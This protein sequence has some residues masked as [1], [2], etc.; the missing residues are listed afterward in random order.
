MDSFDGASATDTFFTRD[1]LDWCP[2]V[3]MKMVQC[4]RRSTSVGARSRTYQNLNVQKVAVPFFAGSSTLGW[5]LLLFVVG[6]ACG[7][8]LKRHLLQVRAGLHDEKILKPCKAHTD[9]AIVERHKP[10][11]LHQRYSMSLSAADPAFGCK[12]T[13]VCLRF[14]VALT[15]QGP[16]GK[17]SGEAFVCCHS[18]QHAAAPDGCYRQM[19]QCHRRAGFAFPLHC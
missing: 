2:V 3:D 12:H 4:H 16:I 8:D 9:E 10:L 11:Q 13:R 15:G 6:R 19:V 18:V 5:L 7:Q 14:I 1:P 17:L